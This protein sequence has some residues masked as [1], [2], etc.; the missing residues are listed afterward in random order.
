MGRGPAAA[1]LQKGPSTLLALLSPAWPY[2]HQCLQTLPVSPAFCPCGILETILC[3]T[4]SL[5]D[6]LE[7]LVAVRWISITLQLL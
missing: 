2:R 1:V 4:V 7:F 6:F 3:P 5:H